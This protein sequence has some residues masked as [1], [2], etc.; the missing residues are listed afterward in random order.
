[1][2]ITAWGLRIKFWGIEDN[3]MAIAFTGLE[4]GFLSEGIVE[5]V[6]I[7]F[8]QKLVL[9]IGFPVLGPPLVAPLFFVLND[10]RYV[11]NSIGSFL[12]EKNQVT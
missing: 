7:G 9:I 10:C 5:N 8:L 12:T 2:E 1:M 4:I 3:C 6:G 11:R